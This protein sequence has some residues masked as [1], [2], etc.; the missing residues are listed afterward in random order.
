MRPNI[1]IPNELHQR[2]KDLQMIT[3]ADD[4]SESYI[5]ALEAGVQQYPNPK[6]VSHGSSPASEFVID[7]L[8]YISY[9][10]PRGFDNII[11]CKLPLFHSEELV[12]FGGGAG[13]MSQAELKQKM[14]TIAPYLDDKDVDNRF[15]IAQYAGQWVGEGL[16]SFLGALN[17]QEARYEQ[18]SPRKTHD[19]EK[20]IFISRITPGGLLILYIQK[21]VGQDLLENM[22]VQF[23]T[24]GV[25]LQ[26]RGFDEIASILDTSLSH[27]QFETHSSNNVL[28]RETLS[29]AADDII[30]LN[31]DTSGLDNDITA[32]KIRNPITKKDVEGMNDTYHKA[33]VEPEEIICHLSQYRLLA[34]HQQNGTDFYLTDL[35][36][37]TLPTHRD[38]LYGVHCCGDWQSTSTDS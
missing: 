29:L 15:S 36:I 3:G 25:P 28:G 13:S 18:H 2:V 8:D 20:A 19:R 12:T 10:D 21:R 22:R 16:W 24:D 7:D 23:V 33:L 34:D 6:Y 11:W 32:L 5:K 17:N 27:A 14:K 37:R 9:T 26:T 4:L 1:D 35:K 30:E 38:G 31:V